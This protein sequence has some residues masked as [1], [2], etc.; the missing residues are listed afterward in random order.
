MDAIILAGGRGTR[1]M[2]LAPE[3]HKPLLPVNGIPMVTLAVDLAIRAGVTCPVVV[4]APANAEAICGALDGRPALVV[5]QRQPLGAGHALLLGLQASPRP[6]VDCDRVLVLLSDNVSTDE[7]VSKV[8]AHPTAVGIQY[9]AREHA[10]RFA[11]L[12]DDGRWVEKEPLSLDGHA[13]ACWVGPFIGWRTNMTRVLAEAVAERK[14]NEEVYVG[15]HLGKFMYI[16]TKC[17]LVQVDSLDLGVADEYRR[18][19]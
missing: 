19:T 4:A 11:R 14:P 5:I 3:F 17:P 13:V 2:E 9:I 18:L 15:P 16:E 1:V 7:D 10:F 12:D 8:A 6:F